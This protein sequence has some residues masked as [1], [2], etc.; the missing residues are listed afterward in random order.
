MICVYFIN[1]YIYICTLP[2]V[3]C[4][5]SLAYFYWCAKHCRRPFKKVQGGWVSWIILA[6]SLSH[7]YV[8]KP[9]CIYIYIYLYIH[10]LLALWN[11]YHIVR[12]IRFTPCDAQSM[13]FRPAVCFWTPA[14]VLSRTVRPSRFHFPGCHFGSRFWRPAGCIWTPLRTSLMTRG[15]YWALPHHLDTLA[16]NCA[17]FLELRPV[18]AEAVGHFGSLH[19]K[20]YEKGPEWRSNWSPKWNALQAIFNIFITLWWMLSRELSGN[21][22]LGVLF[23]TSCGSSESGTWSRP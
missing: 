13:F 21:W 12:H 22:S 8:Y 16:R 11:T 9:I 6:G 17:P 14:G 3:N 20:R 23:A 2:I 5:L 19:R 7:V 1:I 18:L 4:L 10:M 15:P